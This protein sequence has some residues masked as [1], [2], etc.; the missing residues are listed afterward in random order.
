MWSTSPRSTVTKQSPSI[1]MVTKRCEE[2]ESERLLKYE[3]LERNCGARPSWICRHVT[4]TAT[5]PEW[6]L[7]WTSGTGRSQNGQPLLLY[8]CTRETVLQLGQC[9]W[10]W[11]RVSLV[12]TTETPRGRFSSVIFEIYCQ[13]EF[14]FRQ[15]VV[16]PTPS[17]KCFAHHRIIF[18]F[19]Y[20]F[21]LIGCSKPLYILVLLHLISHGRYRL[22]LVNCPTTTQ[23]VHIR[24]RIIWQPL[25]NIPY[26]YCTFILWCTYFQMRPLFIKFIFEKFNVKWWVLYP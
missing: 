24:V 6:A 5:W 21:D 14:R 11:L 2:V 20:L 16:L 12:V 1:S 10:P 8:A 15:S 9:R 22:D 23:I 25:Q 7:G 19:S 17:F 18:L 26:R 3:R 4:T 13:L